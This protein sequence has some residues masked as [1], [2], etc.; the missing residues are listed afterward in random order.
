MNTT[1]ETSIR[2]HLTKLLTFVCVCILSVESEDLRV[3]S[4][5]EIR[6]GKLSF[7]WAGI[8][9]SR[10]YPRNPPRFLTTMPLCR[11]EIW[12]DFWEDQ[13]SGQMKRL[14]SGQGDG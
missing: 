5:P 7:I 9:N 6:P 1:V 4:A 8:L 14:G 13:W 3:E 12:A 2:R 10:V 11:S